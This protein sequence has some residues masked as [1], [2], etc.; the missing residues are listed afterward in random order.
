LVVVLALI[1]LSLFGA[2]LEKDL[3]DATTAFD[4][5]QMTLDTETKEHAALQSAARAVCDALE[6]QE[7]VQSGSSLWSHLTSLYGDVRERVRDTLHTGMRRALALMTSHYAGLDLQRVS[8]GVDETWS[9]V[10]RGVCL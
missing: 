1:P 10:H 3:A 4:V 8:E 6:T 5:L 7:G 9:A 2:G